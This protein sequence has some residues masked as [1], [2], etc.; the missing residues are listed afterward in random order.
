MP[1]AAALLQRPAALL[2]QLAERK[3]QFGA[4]AA[5]DVE[6]LLTAAQSAR[7]RNPGQLIG[8][9]ETLLFLRAYPHSPR[10]LR[11]AEEILSSFEKRM[12]GMPPE[13]FEDPEL[14]GISGTIVS[15]NFSYEFARSLAARHTRDIAIDWDNYEHPERLAS[16]L[17]KWIPDSR[18]DW[19]I[20][21]H[22]DWQRWF[23][24]AQGNPTWLMDRTDPQIYDL[25][26]IP[27]RWD[28]HHSRASRS[29]HRLNS[30]EVFY[31]TQPL[32]TRREVSIAN[33]FAQPRTPLQRL[34]LQEA[35]CV[36]G[37]IVDASAVRYRELYGFL[38]PDLKR[39]RRA[40]FGRG[41][42]CYFFPIPSRWRL[43]KRGYQGGMYFKNGVPI[44]YVEG[45]T[46]GLS[47][48]VGFNLYY[49]FRQGETAWLYARTLKLFGEVLGIER[50]T[51]DPYQLGH[52]NGEAIE[53]GAFWFY[54]KLGFRPES[55]GIERLAVREE[56]KIAHNPAYRTPPATL[57]RLAESG[58][59]YAADL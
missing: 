42:A 21:P 58:M 35:Q 19:A 26:E 24:S 46:S 53:S 30:G 10:S 25:L 40:D 59:F 1:K 39:M 13:P 32:L 9:H 7:F 31:Q 36:W 20:A 37:A 38:H 34:S 6:K 3:T 57:R 15:T 43:P 29:R 50:F 49:T 41:L 5:R 47:M 16:V 54:R 51:I 45:L 33:E 28:L 2:K 52:E 22:P 17:A 56:R 18:E 27:L 11:L 44:G 48:E 4:E 8:L 23:E 55:K 12:S 14:S